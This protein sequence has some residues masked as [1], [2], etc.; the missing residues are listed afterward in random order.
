MNRFDSVLKSIQ[1]SLFLKENQK[2]S[3]LLTAFKNENPT[4]AA[5]ILAALANSTNFNN[6]GQTPVLD[7]GAQDILKKFENNISSLMQNTSAGVV[8]KEV[9]VPG[10]VASTPYIQTPNAAVSPKL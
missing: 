3:P 6:Q 10:G 7:S 8:S 5:K 9:T 2:E 1:N 4:N